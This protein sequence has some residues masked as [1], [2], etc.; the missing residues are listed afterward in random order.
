MLRVP[1]FL[2]SAPCIPT[3]WIGGKLF[4]LPHDQCSRL[5]L[6]MWKPAMRLQDW[7]I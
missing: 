4:L 7:K 6:R 3:F 2:C 1:C 5:I